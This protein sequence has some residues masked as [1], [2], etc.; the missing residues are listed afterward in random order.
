[1]VFLSG[2]LRQ[3]LQF[4]INLML[5]SISDKPDDK[6]CQSFLGKV[7]QTSNSQLDLL[8]ELHGEVSILCL[9]I[10][11]EITGFISLT[12]GIDCIVACCL[13]NVVYITACVFIRS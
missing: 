8:L 5:K 7:F 13:I 1:M 9:K 12:S 6:R 10:E 4:H 3:V 11:T 2:H